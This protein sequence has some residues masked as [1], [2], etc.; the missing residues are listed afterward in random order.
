MAFWLPLLAA[1]GMS[2]LQQGLANKEERN[3]IKAEN[4][5][6]LKTDLDNLGATARDIANLGVM[7]AS[8]RKQA[9]ASQVEAKRQGM[10][11]GGSAEAQAGAFGVKGASVDA[12]ALDIEREVGE[13]LIQ[14]DDN[15]DNQMWNLAEQAHSIQAQAK[16][17]LLGQK[18]TTAGQRSP[19]VAGLMSAGSLYASQ[20]FKFGATPKGGN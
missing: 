2:A 13:A 19:L 8:Y 11:A 18:S 6:R 17:G 10:L 5:A 14:I 1:G 4:K 9:V 20:Y 7:A 3:K 16:A 12:V 15:L